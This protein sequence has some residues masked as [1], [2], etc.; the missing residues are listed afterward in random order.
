MYLLQANTARERINLSRGGIRLR[1]LPSISIGEAVIKIHPGRQVTITD[2]T[3]EANRTLLETFKD[4]LKV[5]R[6]NQT[7]APTE[8]PVP[9]PAPKP[10]PEP[11]PP[12]PVEPEEPTEEDLF[13]QLVREAEA[14]EKLDTQPK[15]KTRR[16]RRTKAQMAE[17]NKKAKK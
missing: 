10:E 15:P 6:L 11:I 8:P 12:A 3:Y 7:E 13:A 2:E 17:A 16:P 9:E 5:T 14:K 4:S 1:R